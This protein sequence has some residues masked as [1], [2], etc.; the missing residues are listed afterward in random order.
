MRT[1]PS[2]LCSAA[3]GVV[4]AAS[5]TGQANAAEHRHHHHAAKVAE[6]AASEA[7]GLSAEVEELK[8]QVQAL[9]AK[10]DAQSGAQA[11]TQAVAV[12]A[13][14]TAQAAASEAQSAQA[15]ADSEIKTIPVQVAT[16]VD[17]VKPKTD[18][19]YYKGVSI[20]MGGFAAAEGIYRSHDETA[21]VG[22]SYSSI[23]YA[24][25][26]AGRTGELRGTARQ[27]RYSLLVQGQPMADLTAS[28]YGEFDFLGAAQT[29]NSKES[30]S[31]Q[32][33]T[34]VVYGQL[35]ST[36]GWHLLA[37]D[38]WSLVT[39]TTNG[40]SP[41]SEVAPSTIEA[42]YVPGFAWARQPEVRLT[43]DFNKTLWLSIAADSPQTTFAN[44]SV[45][46][47]VTLTTTQ[48][49]T[50]Q[51]FNGTN[52]S[53]NDL[54]DFIGKAAF[55]QNMGGHLLHAEVFGIWRSYLDRVTYAP[56][57]GNQ[58]ALLGLT[59]GNSSIHSSGGGVG[60]SVMF[61]LVPHLLDV[62]GSFLTGKGIGRYGSAQLSDVTAEANGRLAAIPE[63]MWMVGGTLHATKALDIYAYGGE[64]AESSKTFTY[65][66]LPASSVFGFDTLPGSNNA[67]CIIEGGSCSA[68]T[69]NIW[70]VTGGIWDKVYQGSFGQVR[71][72]LQYSHTEKEGFPDA[73]TGFAPR[74]K[75][76][77]VFTSFRYYPF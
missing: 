51:F 76:D 4:W 24:N 28:F 62:Q 16:A 33:R 75:E 52:Y 8:A 18:K 60:G 3:L 19:I 11:Q 70:Q 36:S 29:A 66:A 63:T 32:P 21:D 42:Q 7:A 69:K 53:L 1:K 10:L 9:E 38:T 5:F 45:A 17:K 58:A 73:A 44:T 71:I 2:L 54:P 23:P 20:T 15:A 26:R 41:R 43:K 34:R 59:A 12:Q 37:G 61:G 48:A 25:D 57:A 74:A 64:E 14:A 40:I 50:S 67:G 56:A 68:V 77:M 6:A 55:E 13:Q 30:N 35:D 22:S 39:L 72:G 27:S 65:S 47:G 31:Y 49:P 46:S